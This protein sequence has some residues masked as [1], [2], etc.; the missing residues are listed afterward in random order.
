MKELPLVVGIVTMPDQHMV[1]RN[2]RTDS[3]TP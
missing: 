2:G 1:A 3:H